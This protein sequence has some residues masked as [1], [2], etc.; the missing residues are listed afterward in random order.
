MSD[1]DTIKERLSIEEVVSSYMQLI[2]AGS[3][4]KACCPFHNEKSPSFFVSPARGTFYCFG[5]GMKGDVFTFVE[6]FEGLDFKGAL[7]ILASRAGVT[8]SRNNSH[9][10]K[11]KERL[12]DLME[13]VCLWYEEKYSANNT[14]QS[15]VSSRGISSEMR[16]SFRIGYTSSGWSDASTY[17]S[18]KGYTEIEMEHAGIIKKGDRGN[19]DVFRGRLM[20]PIR[21][22]SGRI[23]AFSGRLIDEEVKGPKYVNSPDTQLYKKGDTLYGLFEAKESIRSEKSAIITEGQI[24]V[25]LLHQYGY[26]NTVAMS[27]TAGPNT[28]SSHNHFSILSSLSQKVYSALDGDTA[29][30]KASLK[31]A[32]TT[33]SLGL[34]TFIVELPKGKDPAD[35]LVSGEKESWEK[36]L[37]SSSHAILFFTKQIL[38][39]YEDK[40][41]QAKKISEVVLPLLI[42]IEH[43]TEYSYFL[44]EISKI[45]GLSV[46][47]LKE[48]TEK[49]SRS[50]YS[51]QKAEDI[52]VPQ[53]KYNLI[54][55]YTRR[56]FG[57]HFLSISKGWNSESEEILTCLKESH[58]DDFERFSDF[59]EEN[60]EELLFELENVLQELEEIDLKKAIQQS[61]FL[62][63]EHIIKKHISTILSEIKNTDGDTDIEKINELSKKLQE[64]NTKLDKLTEEEKS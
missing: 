64:E 38:H 9:E 5:C 8:L 63:S 22:T 28:A 58:G 11:E 37:D 33:L 20:F 19:Y 30:V 17:L 4:K 31:L 16:K 51:E 25:V 2:D 10:N 41:M 12:Y 40:R 23:I 61:I 13:D 50:Q 57:F 26:T 59:A 18:S 48:D 14:A 39:F 47:A 49:I 7:S 46:E 21:D 32:H 53:I 44:N 34:D 3:Y 24:D 56:L 54:Q 60:K 35:I 6:Q 62:L 15:Y 36:S 42:Y 27:G 29:G 45:T 55:V 43:Q 52:V 1:I